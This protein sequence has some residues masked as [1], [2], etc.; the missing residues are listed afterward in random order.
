MSKSTLKAA[1]YIRVSTE[2]QKKHGYSLSGQ[3]EELKEYAKQKGYEVFDVYSD[4]GYSGKN[5]NR[6][7]VQRM[8]RDMSNNK[9][10]VIIVWKVDRISRSNKDVLSLIDDE[11]KPRNMKLLVKTC[12]IDSSTTNGYMFISL[13][14]TFAEYERAVIIERVTAGME[15]VARDGEW[16]GG[17]VL[18][19]DSEDKQLVI[20]EEESKIVKEIY[21]MRAEGLGYKKIADNLNSKGKKT[22]KDNSFSIPAIKLI[23]E[24]EV[25]IGT[26]VWGK[27]RNWEEKRRGGKN[28]SPIKVENKHDA[29]IDI[30]LWNRV[31]EIKRINNNTYSTNRN[32]NG[33]LFLTGLLKCPVCGAGTVMSKT[34]K[35]NGNGYHIYYMCQNYH[36]KGKTVCKPNLIKKEIVENKVLEAI[37]EVICDPD[38]INEV[39]TKLELEKKS[40]VADLTS[41]LA[42]LKREIKKYKEEQLNL[43]KQLLCGLKIEH[44][45]RVSD[46]I[47]DRLN[48]LNQ[49]IENIERQIERNNLNNFI[50]KEIIIDTLKN[51]DNLFEK[52]NG[53]EKKL[54]IRSLIKNVEM[55]KDRKEIKHIAFWFA[56]GNGPK[57]P[58]G[59]PPSK[60]RRTVS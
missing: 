7:E 26:K 40:G 45:N 17:K 25:Y 47:Q 50:T 22:K 9:F 51:F 16:N 21:N 19:Y 2:E 24:N 43:D 34:K 14:G 12:D 37:K 4:G 56:E 20:N 38:L 46:Q 3:A 13:L 53:E 31:Q 42:L 6:P 39:I 60:V 58:N 27:Y 29:I 10:D 52:A 36:S 41:N 5:F 11:L 18:G 55:E 23:L 1:L 57:P 33:N 49:S 28:N 30:E 44:Y 59:L 35:R 54:L 32:F 48:E 8:F 15:K